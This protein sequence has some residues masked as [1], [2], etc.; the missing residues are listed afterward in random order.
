[1]IDR[2]IR[3][4]NNRQNTPRRAR[5]HTP[6]GFRSIAS[7]TEDVDNLTRILQGT[8]ISMGTIGYDQEH[9]ARADRRSVAFLMVGP[10]AR[11]DTREFGNL[12]RG[13]QHTLTA[14]SAGSDPPISATGNRNGMV[15]IYF[16]HLSVAESL[17]PS[18]LFPVG[19]R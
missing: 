16:R 2:A 5:S 18:D 3:H 6:S 10:R 11:R 7:R 15:P 17:R 12:V 8:L 1:M 13:A 4:V 19:R 9:S 14:E